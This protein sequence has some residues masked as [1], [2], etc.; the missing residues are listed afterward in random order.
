MQ[1]SLRPCNTEVKE[2]IIGMEF[3]SLPLPGAEAKKEFVRHSIQ[4]CRQ[5]PPHRARCLQA[6]LPSDEQRSDAWR[7]QWTSVHLDMK[8]KLVPVGHTFRTR[9][10]MFG[11]PSWHKRRAVLFVRARAR[12]CARA[13]AGDRE[14]IYL[15]L[16]CICLFL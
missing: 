7:L 16:G 13:R 15:D 3:S 4:T 1:I 11:I 5:T 12:A 14:N 8:F 6:G 10:G 2:N 9:T